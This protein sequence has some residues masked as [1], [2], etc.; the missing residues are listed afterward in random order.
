MSPKEKQH[1]VSAA[2]SA[3]GEAYTQV[4]P[5][6]HALQLA[7]AW[8]QR[9]ELSDQMQP[10]VTK[11]KRFLHNKLCW[12]PMLIKTSQF[13]TGS[14]A[15][16]VPRC[17]LKCCL[18][19][20]TANIQSQQHATPQSHRYHS[21][22]TQAHVLPSW[23]QQCAMVPPPTQG[24]I[25][26]CQVIIEEMKL[27]TPTGITSMC[28][29]LWKYDQCGNGRKGFPRNKS[30]KLSKSCTHLEVGTCPRKAKCENTISWSEKYSETEMQILRLL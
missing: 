24:R 9:I 4:L 28:Y 20:W 11:T 23:G 29:A 17:I 19:T 26:T 10:W 1:T 22:W 3:A 2:A 21:S 14:H 15:T 12:V 7:A 30:T 25:S 16:V 13:A 18:R 5:Q 27:W 8:H 6:P